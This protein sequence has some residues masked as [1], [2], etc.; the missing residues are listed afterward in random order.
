MEVKVSESPKSIKDRLESSDIRSLNN[1]IDVTNYVMRVV[2]HP[3]HVFDYD[4][5]ATKTLTIRESK[6][7]EQIRTLDN[8][9]HKLTGGDIVAEGTKGEIVDLLGVMGLENSVVTNDTKR[10]LFF[11]DNNDPHRMRKTSMSLGIRSEAV[12][13]N[14]KAL[15]PELAMDALL[16]GIKLYKELAKG[17]ILSSIIDIYPNKISRKEIV[18]PQEKIQSIIGVNIS[19]KQSA[20]ILESLGFEVEIKDDK[21]IVLPPSLRAQDVSIPEDVIEEIAR[22]YG[23]YNISDTLPQQGEP[24]Y[25][26]LDKNIFYWED[27]IKDALKYWGFT[28]VYTYPMVSEELFEGPTTDAVMIQNPLTEEFLYMRRTL[29]PSLLR[30]VKQN[31]SQET[32]NIFEIANVYHKRVK[33]LPDELP[34]LA[35]VIKKKHASFYEMKGLIEQIAQELGINKLLFKQL[36][37]K[38]GTSIYINKDLIGEI[39]ILDNDL[40]DAELDM[41]TLLKYATRK[42]IYKPMSKYPPVVEDLALTTSQNISIGDI[43]EEIKKQHPLVVDVSLLDKYHDTRTFHIVYQSHQKNLTSEEVGKIRQKI[44]SALNVKYHISVK[45]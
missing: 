18:V 4:R 42:K 17:K 7:G 30:V 9:T 25:V 37:D 21:L 13:L 19:L 20:E 14:E 35:I 40:I 22:V 31:K 27:V 5:L 33:D 12:I 10:I 44:L 36:S 6:K 16:Y 43:I 39:E 23:Y 38:T 34:K 11:I 32:I 8:K 24:S 28:E 29:V 41:N 26:H 45:E 3:T 1:I 2:G 15:D